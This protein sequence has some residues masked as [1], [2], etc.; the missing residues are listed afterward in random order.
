MVTPVLVKINGILRG[1][2]HNGG[3]PTESYHKCSFPVSE[4]IMS[5]FCKNSIITS[6]GLLFSLF[7][8]EKK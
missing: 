3:H 6:M 8:E 5:W 2:S 4:K 7:D 1:W